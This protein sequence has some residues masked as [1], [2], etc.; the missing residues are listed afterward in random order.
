MKFTSLKR[1]LI[2]FSLISIFILS[3]QYE[4]FAKDDWTM[5]RSENFQMVGNAKEKDLR[6]VALKLEQFRYAFTQLFPKL[7]FN[8]S[9]PTNVVV[10]KNEKSFKDFKPV[11][12]GK[13]RDW[14]AGYF[15]PGED[16][17]YIVLSTEGEKEQ[18]YRIIF[19]EY[20]HFLI[21]NNLGKS[22][23][24]PW[25]NEGYAEYFE[26]MLIEK[27]KEVTLGGLNGNHLRLL[28]QTKL[29]PL[30]TFFNIDYYSLNRQTSDG[31]GVF[32][33]TSLGFNAL[34]LAFR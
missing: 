12:E 27:D 32:L 15:Q 34:F 14:V 31:V 3:T 1:N 17:N 7:K 23:V 20:T 6:R 26:N 22:N 4:V 28:S 24:P 2:L 29:I 9:I 30:E 19:H 18:T 25:V 33:C 10:F 16:V 11:D 13:R 8:S 5:V 21:N